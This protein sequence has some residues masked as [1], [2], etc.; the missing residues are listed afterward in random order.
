[1]D[2]S[3]RKAIVNAVTKDPKMMEQLS[4]LLQN[5]DIQKKL[6]DLLK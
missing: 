6:K 4:G 2:K 1:M 5:E 3:K